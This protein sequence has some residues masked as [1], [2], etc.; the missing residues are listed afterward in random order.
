MLT[1]KRA[2]L[3]LLIFFMFCSIISWQAIAQEGDEPQIRFGSH[4][5][6]GQNGAGG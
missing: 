6:A 1:G 5:E 3:A 4:C 2:K